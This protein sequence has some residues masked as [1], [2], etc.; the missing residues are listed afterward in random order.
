MTNFLLN[1]SSFNAFWSCF[2]LF[3][4]KYFFG[5]GPLNME[6]DIEIICL[7]NDGFPNI[8][9]SFI[10]FVKTIFNSLLSNIIKMHRYTENI[11]GMLSQ[12]HNTQM[13]GRHVRG[14]PK[15]G[16]GLKKKIFARISMCWQVRVHSNYNRLIFIIIFICACCGWDILSFSCFGWDILFFMFFVV[17]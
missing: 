1:F 14:K 10:L 13:Y 11:H 16:G 8:V 4:D 12:L 15:E 5:M 6:D 17:K 3:C 9:C 7:F 2:W